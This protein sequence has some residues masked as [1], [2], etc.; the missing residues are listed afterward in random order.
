MMTCGSVR[1][2]SASTGSACIE[3]HPRRVAPQATRTTIRR[4]RAE[5]PTTPSIMYVRVR[6]L[7]ALRI[8]QEVSGLDDRF[9]DVQ[10]VDD[11]HPVTN[12]PAGL[13]P[14]SLERPIGSTYKN[15]LL[16]S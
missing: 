13:N 1:S 7:T 9:T 3:R 10:T 11:L 4:W 12:A 16:H 5:S 15:A 8:E 2:G 14:A 6:S